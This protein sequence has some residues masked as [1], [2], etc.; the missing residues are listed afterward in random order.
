MAAKPTGAASGRPPLSRVLSAGGTCWS[1]AVNDASSSAG[2][3]AAMA[4]SLLRG[5]RLQLAP[6]G[7]QLSA[8]KRRE[9]PRHS[10]RRLRRAH[11]T[12]SR[13]HP[14]PAW[15]SFSSTSTA[16]KPLTGNGTGSVPPHGERPVPNLG[17]A[18]PRRSRSCWSA[19]SSMSTSSSASGSGGCCCADLSKARLT[20]VSSRAA[21]GLLVRGSSPWDTGKGSTRIACSA[22]THRSRSASATT[23][24]LA[25]WCNR[26]GWCAAR[27]CARALRRRRRGRR[28]RSGPRRSR[29]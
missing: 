25:P 29:R 17:S 15:R 14:S 13:R 6:C 4:T 11:G 2:S 19:T 18:I 21:W 10:A 23:A 28:S 8:E 16:P 5:W 1:C 24:A 12:S 7:T 9:Q 3:R 22:A 27:P 20:R 26:G